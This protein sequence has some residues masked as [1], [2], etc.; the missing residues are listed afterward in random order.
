MVYKSKPSTCP[1]QQHPKAIEV[2]VNPRFLLISNVLKGG[3]LHASI[4]LIT[5]S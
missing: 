1:V 4:P 2:F 5:K 3:S